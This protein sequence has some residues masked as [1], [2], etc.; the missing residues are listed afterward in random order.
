MTQVESVVCLEDEGMLE[1]IVALWVYQKVDWWKICNKWRY[2]WEEL[3]PEQ[4][5]NQSQCVWFEHEK[6]DY[7]PE[8]QRKHYH[9]IML[10]WSWEEHKYHKEVVESSK[11]R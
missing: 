11:D 1:T 6:P 7:E 10:V 3:F 2:L 8:I 9:T 5:G 4:S